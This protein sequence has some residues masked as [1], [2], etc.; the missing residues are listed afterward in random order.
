[1]SYGLIDLQL[2]KMHLRVYSR[3][4]SIFLTIGSFVLTVFTIGYATYQKK[5]FYPTVIHITKSSPSMAVLYLQGA[6]LM[7]LAGKAFSRIF[8]GSLRPTEVEHLVERS[9]Y[10]ITETCLAFTVF[11]D[12]FS[13]RF[14]IMF[15][16]LL[17]FK[18]FHWLTE[19]RIDYMER[20][21]V[22]SFKFHVR[23]TALLIV[24]SLVDCYFIRYAYSNVVNR[25]ASVQIVFGFEYMILGISVLGM[26]AHYI[27]HTVDSWQP[28]AWD[29]KSAYLLYVDLL[30]HFSRVVLYGLFLTLMLRLHTFPLFLVRPAYLSVSAFKKSLRDVILSRRAITLMNTMFPSL[31]AAE[32]A[33]LGS[34]DCI[35]IIC[36]EDMTSAGAAGTN[37]VPNVN[38]APQP[39]QSVIKRLPCQH[40]F[41]A[42]C[43]RTWFQRQQT[44]PTCRMD[45]LRQM[46]NGG[47][48]AANQ[49]QPGASASSRAASANA[50]AASAPPATGA[51]SADSDQR[52]GGPSTGAVNPPFNMPPWMF[53][54]PP[55]SMM[56]PNL[57]TAPSTS[58]AGSSSNV[59]FSPP[60]FPPPNNL[61]FPGS[62][63]SFF[64][65]GLN[66]P[67]L[68]NV[69]VARMS[70]EELRILEEKTREGVQ[71]RLQCLERVRVLLDAA[72]LQMNA[73]TQAL[74]LSQ[75]MS[76]LTTQVQT[77][78]E[79]VNKTTEQPSSTEVKET[80]NNSMKEEQVIAEKE[81][82]TLDLTSEQP[83]S[84]SMLQND[85]P[86]ST[87]EATTP[88]DDDERAIV[89]QRRL[90]HFNIT[91]SES[92]EKPKEGE[93]PQQD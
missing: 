48:A 29:H 71:A 9:W 1:V 73:Y 80:P 42:H 6:V 49:R 89:R 63:G 45:I 28:T 46:R 37:N 92:N 20:T 54:P 39:A 84:S 91:S 13:T 16:L 57:N 61:F 64:N 93:H 36:R 17:F 82:L 2:A 83:T 26:M 11:R 7:M 31:T 34:S 66:F 3:F 33:E 12:D 70:D 74:V 53:F 87:D 30:L 88:A 56:M 44:C 59:P 69:D 51:A 67:T 27:L 79:P 22:I 24:L 41:H 72:M 68:S 38:V 43:L 35:C 32:I 8:F 81:P 76:G 15:A 23:A 14:V 4:T 25:G 78:S 58:Q 52:M 10:A 60:V 77:T 21:P 85:L 40:V 90:K 18:C 86:D 55:P 47:A 75:G 62:F 19:D 5:Q 50:N 65:S